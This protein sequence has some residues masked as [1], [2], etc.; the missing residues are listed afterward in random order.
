GTWGSYV[1]RSKWNCFGFELQTRDFV[2]LGP[3]GRLEWG[4]VGQDTENFINGISVE[5]VRWLLTYLGRM[6]DAQLRDGLRASG[7][8]PAETSCFSRALRKRIAALQALRGVRSEAP[9]SGPLTSARSG[10][11]RRARR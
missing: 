9:G 10:H 3:R 4:Y 1:D 11:R 8:T 2:R 6:S 7:A 5:D